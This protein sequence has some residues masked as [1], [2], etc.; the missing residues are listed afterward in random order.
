MPVAARNTAP[1]ALSSN[2]LF[3]VTCQQEKLIS[4]Y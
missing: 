3:S 2:M 4:E 1:L